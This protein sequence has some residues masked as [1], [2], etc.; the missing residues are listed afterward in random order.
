[1]NYQSIRPKIHNLVQEYITNKENLDI[2]SHFSDW[3]I[4]IIFPDIFRENIEKYKN[5]FNEYNLDYKIFY[6]HKTNKSSAFLQI[7]EEE[8]IWMDVASKNELTHA[9]ACG[10][11]WERISCSGPKSNDF[12]FLAMKHGCLISIDWIH[13]LQQIVEIYNRW[14]FPRVNLLIRINDL[15]SSDRVIASK[16]TKF[17]LSQTLLPKVYDLLNKYDFLILQGIHFHFDEHQHEIKA[18]AIENA[19]WILQESYQ[20]WFTPS[21]IDIWW[22]MRWEE[23]EDKKDWKNYIDFLSDSKK[24][25]LDTHTW[26]NRGYWIHVSDRW[27]IEGRELVEKRYREIDPIKFLWNVL[28]FQTFQWWLLESIQDSMFQIMIEP[29][30]SLTL[31]C[32]FT[33]LKITGYKNLSN[34]DEAIIVN[35]NILNLSSKMW[36]YFTDPILISKNQNN[37]TDWNDNFYGFIFWNLCRDDDIL[38]QKKVY[39]QSKPS[40]WDYVLFMNTSSYISDFEDASPISQDKWMKIVVKKQKNNFKI[41]PDKNVI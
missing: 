40:I 5:F 2:V 15:T 3:P 26:W 34:W 30:Y 28:N 33:L 29:G 20:Y 9:L 8:N 41:Y 35:A 21:I 19:I 13:E 31:W 38:I 22:G 10:F 6:A 16:N 25:W 14:N 18:W 24:Q 39:F 4:H 12:L 11:T 27:W 36:E 1:M 23:L 37:V 7:A 17:W 32:G